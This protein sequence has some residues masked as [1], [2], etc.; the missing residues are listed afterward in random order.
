MFEEFLER[1]LKLLELRL[2]GYHRF[3]IANPHR[4]QVTDA[5]LQLKKEK[6]NLLTFNIFQ[7]YTWCIIYK[8]TI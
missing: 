7:Q 5:Y 1:F 4:Q 6:F 8:L 2:V 3:E